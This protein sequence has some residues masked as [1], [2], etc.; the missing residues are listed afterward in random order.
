MDKL[1]KK[2]E[3]DLKEFENMGAGMSSEY[4]TMCI[5]KASYAREILDYLKEMSNEAE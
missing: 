5:S 2:I 1:I 3:E 4:Y